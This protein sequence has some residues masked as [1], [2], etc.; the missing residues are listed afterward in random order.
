ML[1]FQLCFALCTVARWS[2]DLWRALPP[3][4]YW[5]QGCDPRRLA[6]SL[7]FRLEIVL[8]LNFR[9]QQHGRGRWSRPRVGDPQH[10]GEAR[11]DSLAWYRKWSIVEDR[12]DSRRCVQRWGMGVNMHVSDRHGPGSASIARV[13]CLLHLEIHDVYNRL[14]IPSAQQQ[15]Q[16]YYSKELG[17][18]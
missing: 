8:R 2:S 4:R 18:D 7:D 16:Q 6:F 12:G 3:L 9:R 1:C 14:L 13:A 17:V 5:Q 11:R 15:Q 10:Y